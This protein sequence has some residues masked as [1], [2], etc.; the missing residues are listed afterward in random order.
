MLKRVDV[1]YTNASNFTPLLPH[2]RIDTMSDA[3]LTALY[4]PLRRVQASLVLYADRLSS[5]IATD[6][7]RDKGLLLNVRVAF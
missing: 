7:Y 4:T 2:D 1:D 6:S 5:T 3:S